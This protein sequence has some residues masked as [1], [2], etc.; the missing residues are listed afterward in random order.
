MSFFSDLSVPLV[1]IVSLVIQFLLGF[2]MS[3]V[4]KI[5]LYL[6]TLLVAAY[7][8]VMYGFMPLGFRVH[9]DMKL[10][11]IAHQIGIYTHVFAS[12]C[13]VFLLPF[14]FS[15]WLRRTRP[16]L[17]RYS[18]RVYLV[19][20]VALGG[21]SA[22]YMSVFA[23]GGML[24]KLGFACLA[25]CWLGPGLQ[26]YRAIRHGDVS[27]HRRWM[28]RNASLTLAAVT[29]RVYLPLS[30]IAT[31]PFETAY[32]LI[33]WLCWVPN[34]LVAELII[35]RMCLARSSTLEADGGAMRV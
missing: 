13:A 29:L 18:G 7:A 19:V 25:L 33:A 3:L 32:P 2:F 34:S 21:L 28:I 35:V 14:Q 11:F 24:A 12:V 6:F 5:C 16:Y 31:I 1:L 15:A 23:F 27:A 26:A 4:A 9:P 30:M 10:N 8:V 22:L 20:G 17:H